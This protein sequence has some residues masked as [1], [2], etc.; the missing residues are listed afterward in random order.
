MSIASAHRLCDEEQYGDLQAHGDDLCPFATVS[1]GTPD[2]LKY[3]EWRSSRSASVSG[4]D[5]RGMCFPKTV[6]ETEALPRSVKDLP[7]PERSQ[8][9]HRT[10]PHDI[11]ASLSV[12][13]TL[14][15]L[16]AARN[17]VRCSCQTI[18]SPAAHP[19]EP[20]KLAS[21]GRIRA[22][23]P[24]DVGRPPVLGRR[25]KYAPQQQPAGARGS[26]EETQSQTCRHHHRQSHGRRVEAQRVPRLVSGWRCNLRR[27][28]LTEPQVSQGLAQQHQQHRQRAHRP[29]F[30]QY[31]IRS[32]QSPTETH[33]RIRP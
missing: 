27:S 19:S 26:G 11:H 5:S 29:P 22:S 8:P 1:H 28:P 7:P 31:Q 2:L 12:L 18:S 17:P 30:P 6:P 4:D 9:H 20:R 14:P 16:S 32:A 15:F 3:S 13:D 33:R 21:T 10:L 23:Q 25:Q 24:F